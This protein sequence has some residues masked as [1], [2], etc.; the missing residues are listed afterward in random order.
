MAPL[1][2]SL[3]SSLQLVNQAGQADLT[4]EMLCG[5]GVP[6]VRC[7]GLSSC[8]PVVLSGKAWYELVHGVTEY[9]WPG[10]SAGAAL[11][12]FTGLHH[13]LHQQSDPGPALRN[14]RDRSKTNCWEKVRQCSDLRTAMVSVGKRQLAP[15]AL[16]LQQ[17]MQFCIA[18]IHAV[19]LGTEED[20]AQGC[21]SLSALTLPLQSRRARMSWVAQ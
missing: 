3:L 16:H 1:L 6:P 7:S 17:W 15:C 12:V 2:G 8:V 21:N 11:L 13:S 4:R 19:G 20:P 18:T 14:T 10:W 9:R 5:A